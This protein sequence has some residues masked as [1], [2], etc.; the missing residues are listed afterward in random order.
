MQKWY[1]MNCL[2]S[3]GLQSEQSSSVTFAWCYSESPQVQFAGRNIMCGS[4]QLVK[5]R[6]ISWFSTVS[7]H[8]DGIDNVLRHTFPTAEDVWNFNHEESP[9]LA[10]CHTRSACSCQCSKICM[11]SRNWNLQVA[12]YEFKRV[13]T[14]Q[15]Q[16]WKNW[17]LL[18]WIRQIQFDC[19]D[20][21]N[22]LPTFAWL[23]VA[24]WYSMLFVLFQ[25]RRLERQEEKIERARENVNTLGKQSLSMYPCSLLASKSF[26]IWTWFLYLES[27]SND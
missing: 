15:Q 6:Y 12:P 13:T 17:L 8:S 14:L 23:M 2:R 1:S 9:D 11:P 21:S 20:A 26:P 4:N 16:A 19:L 18:S 22:T 25:L 5:P 7:G 3:L 10:C 24:A 27:Q